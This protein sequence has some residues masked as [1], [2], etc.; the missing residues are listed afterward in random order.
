M[1]RSRM[2]A[3]HRFSFPFAGSS[4]NFLQMD[5]WNDVLAFSKS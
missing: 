2:Q 5:F 4:L 3:L 1:R